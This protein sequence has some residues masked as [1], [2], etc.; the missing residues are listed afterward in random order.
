MR[1]DQIQEAGDAREA[2]LL[3]ASLARKGDAVLV[4]ASRGM[5]LETVVEALRRR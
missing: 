3:A 2:G 1:A 4:K 5:H